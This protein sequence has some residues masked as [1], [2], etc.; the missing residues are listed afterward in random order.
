[1]TSSRAKGLSE[2]TPGSHVILRDLEGCQKV[3]HIVADGK[4]LRMGKYAAIPVAAILS[5]PYG[6]LLRLSAGKWLRHHGTT[7]APS[8]PGCEEVTE[9]NRDF[10]QDNTAQALTPDQV[11]ELKQTASGEEVV[12]SL[13]SNN[14]TFASKTRFAQEKYIKKKEQKHVQQ[15][16]LLRPTLMDLCETYLQ[17]SRSKV[18]GLRFD[19]LSSMLCHADVRQAGRYLLLDLAGG[20]V[21]AAM[22]RQLCGI[23]AVF[24]TYQSSCPEKAI[25]ELD[26]DEASRRVIQQLPLEVLLSPD[27]L[28]HEWLKEFKVSGGEE[29]TGRHLSRM[30]RTRQRRATFQ[31]YEAAPLE[32]VIVVAGEDDVELASE[33]VEL[34]LRKLGP[35]GRLVVYGRLLQPL[36]ALQG[37]L[38]SSTFVD[39]RLIQLFTRE[40]QVLPQRIHPHMQQDAQLCEGFILSAAKVSDGGTAGEADGAEGGE[41]EGDEDG[42]EGDEDAE[43][44][45]A[46]EPEGKRR[47]L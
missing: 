35:G 1:M 5:S 46:P 27:P 36:A 19:Y 4:P 20:L 18:C 21:A 24:R 7:A 13:C 42:A 16:H 45:E 22:A 31:S 11:L 41:G 33:V 3:F 14:A 2:I 6:S 38:R 40:F 10:A 8:A 9:D 12:K 37:R 39:V 34:G 32:A 43:A 30:E 29:A 15:V 28:A 23:G 25:L 26:L 17:Q 44:P 47:K